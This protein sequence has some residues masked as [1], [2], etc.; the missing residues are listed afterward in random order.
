MN[1]DES[2]VLLRTLGL[3]L[4]ES[5]AYLA[6]IK[7]KELTAKGVGQSAV[8][9]QSRTYDVL[10]S[11]AR[12]GFALATPASPTTY[13]PVPPSKILGS[14]Y[15]AERKK[16]QQGI[17][18]A[19]EEAQAKLEGLRDAYTA[20]TKSFPAKTN[21]QLA[22]RD[23]VWVL[24]TRE[25]I[26]SALIELIREAKSNVLRITRPPELKKGEPL[27]PFYIVGMENRRYLFDA[28]ER[29]VEMR[30]LSLASEIP[31]FSGLEVGEPPERRYLE[32]E[33]D[34]TEKFLLV[35]N[36]SVLL[37]LHDPASSAYG[38]V[39]LAM[40]ST[41]AASIFLDHFEKVWDRGKPLDDVLPKMK[42]LLKEATGKLKEAGLP[43]TQVLF[44]ETLARLGAVS[45]ETVVSELMKKKVQTQDSNAGCDALMRL[46]LVHR[47]NTYRLLVVEHPAKT[48]ASAEK[49]KVPEGRGVTTHK[50]SSGRNP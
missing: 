5:R 15:A 2:V 19:H 14:Q 46:G 30:W 8:I 25:N 3:N 39:A 24:H 33:R 11:L 44:Y 27:D 7:G 37:N 20:L 9:P 45:R 43:R 4:Y 17:V 23:Q 16:I 28:L 35:D 42:G 36:R 10:E 48:V 6:L 41:A 13:V 22:V 38:S 31:S 29:K 34:I 26:E 21:E 32:D 49:L 47:D 18:R 40:Q 12:K 1:D 50:S